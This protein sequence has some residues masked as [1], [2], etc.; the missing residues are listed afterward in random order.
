LLEWAARVAPD[1]SVV[2][3]AASFVASVF[4][5]VCSVWA[6]VNWLAEACARALLAADCPRTFA[7]SVG[8]EEVRL[9][10]SAEAE[11]VDTPPSAAPKDVAAA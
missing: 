4:G 9:R 10:A 1:A 11:V 7:C 5:A 3:P 6:E 2:A 8:R